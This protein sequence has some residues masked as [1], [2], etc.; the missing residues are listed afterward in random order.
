MKLFKRTAIA[1]SLLGAAWSAQAAAVTYDFNVFALD[2]PT[3]GSSSGFFS[4][5]SGIVTPGTV[6]LTG[7]LTDF[8]FTIGGITYDETTAN[9]GYLSFDGA[10]DLVGYYFG[11]D[12]VAGSCTVN[13]GTDGFYLQDGGLLYASS[14]PGSDGS[15]GGFVSDLTLRDTGGNIPEPASLALVLSAGLLAYGSRRRA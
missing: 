3:P 10:G 14:A 1:L 4:Y 15:F 13:S 11:S 9:T 12:C 8:S 6:N 7:L 2:G 5:D